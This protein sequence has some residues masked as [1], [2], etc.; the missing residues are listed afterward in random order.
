MIFRKTI[1][2]RHYSTNAD[3]FGYIP[4]FAI[5]SIMRNTGESK[6]AISNMGAVSKEP[7]FDKLR[8]VNR[9]ERV[10]IS[11][12]FADLIPAA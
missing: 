10:L 9:G 2:S 1:Q 7:L 8:D 11:Y 6:M 5:M 4:L 3:Q 12:C